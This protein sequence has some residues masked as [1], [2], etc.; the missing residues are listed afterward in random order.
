[1]KRLNSLLILVFLLLLTVA[2]SPVAAPVTP[3]PSTR[4]LAATP[5]Q[6]T[7]APNSEDAAWGRVMESARKEGVVVVYSTFANPPFRRAVE[8]TFTP[9]YGVKVEWIVSGGAENKEK[10]AVEQRSKQYVGD[11]YNGGP[12]PM[13]DMMAE[14]MLEAFRPPVYE[15][16]AKDVWEAS[17]YDYDNTGHI[18]VIQGS[19]TQYIVINT[20]LVKPGEYPQSYHDL[21]DPKWKGKIVMFDPTTG[22]AGSFLFTR[23]AE[24]KGYGLEFWRQMAKQN[25]QFQRN[26]DA[27]DR[28]VAL[29]E[30]DIGLGGQQSTTQQYLEAGTPIKLWYPPLDGRVMS[31]SVMSIVRNAPHPNAAKL[32]VNFMLTKEGQ[33]LLDIQGSVPIRRD[34]KFE[35]HSQVRALRDVP[36]KL[37]FGRE[38]SEKS[39]VYLLN[40]TAAEIFGLGK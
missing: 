11:A 2:C 1:M 6:A 10:L 37:I 29:G 34:A 20:N 25:I 7:P 5:V 18:T 26:Y 36:L 8:R 22:G 15:Q 23:L 12:T 27:V 38:L 31:L 21:L 30:R 17:P 32:L 9:K 14:G 13:L 40:R 28:L 3:V 16:T 24:D 4:P 33:D 35:V 39:R 19:I